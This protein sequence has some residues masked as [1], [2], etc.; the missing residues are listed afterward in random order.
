[1]ITPF[2][3]V[4][5]FRAISGIQRRD[6]QLNS[7][8]AS[9]HIFFGIL[10]LRSAS[11][12]RLMLEMPVQSGGWM[13][14]DSPFARAG[15]F[16]ED[17]TW[18]AYSPTDFPDTVFPDIP[19]SQ[20]FTERTGKLQGFRIPDPPGTG[21]TDLMIHF[22]ERLG[23][24]GCVSTPCRALWLSFCSL[25][26]QFRASGIASVPICIAVLPLNTKSNR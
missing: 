18:G 13:S 9:G 14:K 23:S 16:P 2:I 26:A 3:E 15:L 12:D 19:S 4:L 17:T 21:R 25:M 5:L 22:S 10:R 1:M 8:C 11:L 20:V 7:L 6:E 24:E